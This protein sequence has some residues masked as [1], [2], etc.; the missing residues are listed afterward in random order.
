MRNDEWK[1]QNGERCLGMARDELPHAERLQTHEEQGV[2]RFA[3]F[4]VR[5]S[6]FIPSREGAVRVMAGL[7][8]KEN[9]K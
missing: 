1:M 9:E 3:F 5:C 4:V 7:A 8:G 6:F 2:L